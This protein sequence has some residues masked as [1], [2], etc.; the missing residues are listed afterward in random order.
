MEIGVHNPEDNFLKLSAKRKFSIDPGIEVQKNQ[1]DF[2][3]TSDVFFQK[4]KKRKLKGGPKTLDVICI[5]G[6]TTAEQ[7]DR[8]I[9]NSLESLAEDRFIVVHHCNPPTQ[10][11]ARE[12]F[13]FGRSPAGNC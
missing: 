8:A 7:T 5:D 10:W 6:L 1:A 11:H 13:H 4:N 9:A 3:Y 2:S 12:E